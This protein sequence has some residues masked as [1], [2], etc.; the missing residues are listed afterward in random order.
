MLQ[1]EAVDR[2]VRRP[3]DLSVQVLLVPVLR[4]QRIEIVVVAREAVPNVGP[5]AESSSIIEGELAGPTD[6]AAAHDGCMGCGLLGDPLSEFSVGR[7]KGEE[8]HDGD[9]Q[10]VSIAIFLTPAR[11]SSE[12]TLGRTACGRFFSAY[13]SCRNG[14]AGRPKSEEPT[15]LAVLASRLPRQP[16]G[17]RSLDGPGQEGIARGYELPARGD[18]D[19]SMLGIPLTILGRLDVEMLLGESFRMERGLRIVHT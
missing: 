3:F 17:T 14:L 4:R 5:S 2:F 6:S 9:F 12:G 11:L 16:V 8:A 10:L 1:E 7:G 15:M 18:L 13:Q 19:I